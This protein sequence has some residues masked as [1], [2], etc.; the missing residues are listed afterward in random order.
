MPDLALSGLFIMFSLHSKRLHGLRTN[1]A[2]HCQLYLYLLLALV[3]GILLPIQI[4]MN[5]ELARSLGSFPL[6]AAIS[7]VVGGSALIAL[8]ATRLVGQP[9]WSGLAQTPRWSLFGGACGVLYVA[10]SA[11]FASILGTTLTLG[12]VVFGQAIAGLITD[13]YGWLGIPQ[14]RF[15]RNR[16]L[17]VGCL[18]AALV[19]LMQPG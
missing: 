9:D 2:H 10:S 15:T 3:S 13:H 4:G 6:A 16:R 14:H 7:Y 1:L 19:F 17:A 8:L 11:Y 18:L 5:S 12:F